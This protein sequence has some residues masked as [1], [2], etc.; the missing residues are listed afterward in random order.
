MSLAVALMPAFADYFAVLD[1]NSA[2]QR[3]RL[4]ISAAALRQRQGSLHPRPIAFVH[5]VG[6][7]RLSQRQSNPFYPVAAAPEASWASSAALRK[8]AGVES[9]AG[10]A[11][12][13]RAS[14]F[15][16]Y[17][18]PSRPTISRLASDGK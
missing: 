15:A 7:S 2:D 3:V 6:G 11:N 18:L 12:D 9:S 8:F 1:N 14:P 5:G 13:T 4:D 16:L 10:R 17:L